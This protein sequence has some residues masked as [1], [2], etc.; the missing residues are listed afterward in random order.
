VLVPASISEA[1]AKELAL[2]RER[3]KAYIDGKKLSNII[4]VP[5][6]VVNIVLSKG[7]KE[8]RIR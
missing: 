3:V 5:N 7:Q 4:Y 8:G 2:G 6:R 1:E